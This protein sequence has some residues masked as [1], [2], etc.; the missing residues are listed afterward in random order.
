MPV[1]AQDIAKQTVGK[2]RPKEGVYAIP[3][4]D[5]DNRCMQRDEAF[6]ELSDNSLGGEEYGCTVSKLTDTATGGI[7]LDV[8][9]DDSQAGKSL[10]EVIL[11]NR[12]DENT[13]FWRGTSQGKFKR[14]GARL[15]YC[16]EEVQS[17]RREANARDKAEAERKAADQRAKQKQ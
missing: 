9:C 14:P 11:L 8:I 17:L 1:L 4:P 3:G 13:I 6:V 2:W 16:Q 15:L 10:K 12:I 5:H 7:R